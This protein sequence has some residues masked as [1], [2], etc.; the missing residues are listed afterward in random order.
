MSK[1]KDE[2]VLIENEKVL[3]E[4]EKV[5]LSLDSLKKS[6]MGGIV[7]PEELRVAYIQLAIPGKRQKRTN[8]PFF[9]MKSAVAIKKSLI[10][11][12][13]AKT[14]TVA[15]IAVIK[16]SKSSWYIPKG[17]WLGIMEQDEDDEK[18]EENSENVI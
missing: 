17:S 10:A 16:N 9:S 6:L 18:S 15:F 4:D 11:G 2:E 14:E 5:G 1:E 3:T 7:I 8:L 13:F 12:G